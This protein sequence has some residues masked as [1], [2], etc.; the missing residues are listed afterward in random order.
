[1]ADPLPKNRIFVTTGRKSNY[2]FD[3]PIFEATYILHERGLRI[4]A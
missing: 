4:E 1:M 2:G 3:I